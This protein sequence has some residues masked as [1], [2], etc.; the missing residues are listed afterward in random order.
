MTKKE[1]YSIEI[2]CIKENPALTMRKGEKQTVAKVKSL[3]LAYV[4]ANAI[5]KLYDGNC[6]VIVK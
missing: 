2:E 6:Y 4:T 5:N 3:G 1:W